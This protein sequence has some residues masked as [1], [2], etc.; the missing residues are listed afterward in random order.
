MCKTCFLQF[1]ERILQC[2]DCLVL[3]DGLHP[4]NHET[5]TW[6]LEIAKNGME[7]GL[8]C[9]ECGIGKDIGQQLGHN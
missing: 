6:S 1:N 2:Q 4:P 8:C 5:W 7:T 3:W 9:K